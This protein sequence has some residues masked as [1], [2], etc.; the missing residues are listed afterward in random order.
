[1]YIQ[2]FQGFCNFFRRYINDYSKIMAP[3]TSLVRKDV[4]FIWGP[5]QEAAFHCIKIAMI[6]ASVLIMPDPLKPFYMETDASDT[7]LGAILSQIGNGGK[8]HPVAF[9]SK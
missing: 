8:M 1:M 6:S 2:V 5:E 3:L 4:K 7:T 9:Y